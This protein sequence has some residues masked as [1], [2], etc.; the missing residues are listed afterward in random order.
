M[1]YE[2]I[3]LGFEILRA[4]LFFLK[5]RSGTTLQVVKKPEPDFDEIQR[6]VPIEMWDVCVEIRDQI[7]LPMLKTKRIGKTVYM[8]IKKCL[9]HYKFR[10]RYEILDL[11]SQGDGV[12]R[13]YFKCTEY[14]RDQ[15][16]RNGTIMAILKI[17]RYRNLY[18]S[19]YKSGLSVAVNQLSFFFCAKN[20]F[21]RVDGTHRTS[22]ARYL[23]YKKIPVLMI[24]PK[25]ISNLPL[26]KSFRFL[27]SS[28]EEPE[29]DFFEAIP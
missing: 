26:K 25:D 24:T 21:F 7:L 19:I 3:S 9:P 16:A 13:R 23:G 5:K 14:Y 6:G 11:I 29:Q 12:L 22:I 17:Y 18:Y 2:K 4:A 10:Q 15:V 8:D 27:L 28:F 1:V 20:I